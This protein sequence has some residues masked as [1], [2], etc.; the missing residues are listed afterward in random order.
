M[1]LTTKSFR[2]RKEKS[3]RLL[4][5]QPF[6]AQVSNLKKVLERLLDYY[7]V[8][9]DQRLSGFSIPDVN[10]IGN[11]HFVFADLFP[12]FLSNQML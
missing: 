9:L 12:P 10:K 8:R 5:L 7:E 2:E 3:D 1:F 6:C 11:D 4:I